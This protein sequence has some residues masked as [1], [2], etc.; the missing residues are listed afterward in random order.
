MEEVQRVGGGTSSGCEGRCTVVSLAS[1]P[2]P[3]EMVKSKHIWH[4]NC[5]LF[6][7][8]SLAKTRGLKRSVAEHYNRLKERRGN[9]G[10]LRTVGPLCLA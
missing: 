7:Y 6:S 1:E 3:Q 9:G 2:D 10:S 4:W 8:D 5:L